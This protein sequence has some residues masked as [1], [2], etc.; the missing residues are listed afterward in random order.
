MMSHHRSDRLVFCLL[1]GIA[2][3]GVGGCNTTTGVVSSPRAPYEQL[4]LTQS[5]LRSLEEAAIPLRPGDSVAVE[6]ARPVSHADF[7]GDRLYAEAFLRS[8]LAQRGVI[9][10][11]GSP[12]YR[13]HMLMHAFGVDKR[14]VFF[15][16]PPIQSGF[17]P[18]A[19]PELTMYRNVRNRGY[20]R[21]TIDVYDEQAGRLVASSSTVDATVS[22]DEYTFLFIISWSTTDIVPPPL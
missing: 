5:L 22:L 20:S 6:V 2:L 1:T 3:M 14:E 7:S 15:G 8:W 11:H 4:L 16:V 12:T 10:G 13:I 19:L 9:I 21:L 17:W 18:I